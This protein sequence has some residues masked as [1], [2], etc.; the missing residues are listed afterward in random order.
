MSRFTNLLFGGTIL[1]FSVVYGALN[2]PLTGDELVRFYGM[3]I[4]GA[5]IADGGMSCGSARRKLGV[6]R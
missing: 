3:L 2:A 5:V 1:I 6:G 4:L